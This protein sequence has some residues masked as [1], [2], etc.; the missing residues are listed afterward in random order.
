MYTDQGYSD[1]WVG[2]PSE[3]LGVVGEEGFVDDPTE[4]V[5]DPIEVRLFCCITFN[6]TS[7]TRLTF[8]IPQIICYIVVLK[9]LKQPYSSKLSIT[10][11]RHLS[12]G[13]KFEGII[14]KDPIGTI[15]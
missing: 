15:L 6:T 13:P 2:L 14:L 11:V 4:S 5:D 1:L 9:V 12:L 10:S 3:S 8:H 7:S